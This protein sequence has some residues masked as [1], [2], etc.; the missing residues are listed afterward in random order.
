MKKLKILIITICIIFLTGCTV[1]YNIEVNKDT[2][3]SESFS[4]DEHKSAFTHTQIM[5]A[6]IVVN[7]MVEREMERLEEIG[8][9]YK[10]TMDDENVITTFTNSYLNFNE[11]ISKAQPTYTQWFDT[12][13]VVENGDIVEFHAT[14]FVPFST[15]NPSKYIVNDLNINLIIPFEVTSHNA[16]A[17]AIIDNKI[18]YTWN[19]DED[20]TSKE[21]KIN[22]NVAKDAKTSWTFELII[23]ILILAI[24]IGIIVYRKIQ[25]TDEINK[26]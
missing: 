12:I 16:D 4:A 19:I 9:N 13:N 18:I 25:K 2:T 21:I 7:N 22:Y 20:T 10:L 6:N 3:I 23:G 5:E 1:D 17:T 14:D 15:A 11:Y 26:I 24:V 8:Y